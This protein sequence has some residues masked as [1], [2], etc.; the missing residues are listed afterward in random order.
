[1]SD[2]SP[3]NPATMGMVD[4]VNATKGQALNTGELVKAFN[5]LSSALSKLSVGTFTC[6]SSA[7]TSVADSSVTGSSVIILQPTNAA[8]GT[9]QGSAK[10][11]YV[12]AVG[13]GSFTVT[14]ASSTP[15]GSE[16]F[17]YFRNG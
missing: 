13:S 11:L 4:L 16:T 10:C 3:S 12:S 9:L 8:A 17:A 15:T 5:A 1:M 14:T 6:S 2:F 7:S